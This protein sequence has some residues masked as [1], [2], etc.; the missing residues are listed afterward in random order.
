MFLLK[1]FSSF[2]LSIEYFMNY[3]IILVCY[4]TENFSGG[5]TGYYSNPLVNVDIPV[6]LVVRKNT[7]DLLSLTVRLQVL[8]F[9]ATMYISF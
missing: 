9:S 5:G 4:I 3:L 1:I 2:F 8:L 6:T 7:I